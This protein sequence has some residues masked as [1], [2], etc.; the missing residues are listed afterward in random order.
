MLIQGKSFDLQDALEE[1]I[2]SGNQPQIVQFLLFSSEDGEEHEDYWK[3]FTGRSEFQKVAEVIST[4]SEANQD[5]PKS[6][7]SV[8]EMKEGVDTKYSIHHRGITSFSFADN[9]FNRETKPLLTCKAFHFVS[10][11]ARIAVEAKLD[12]RNCEMAF[13]DARRIRKEFF[14]QCMNYYSSDE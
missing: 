1:K 7:A 12:P 5:I 10:I 6:R 2:V 14:R 4:I 9:Q 11:L 13:D 3:E 8:F